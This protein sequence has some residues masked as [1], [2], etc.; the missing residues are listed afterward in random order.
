MYFTAGV[1]GNNVFAQDENREK[2][3]AVA[4]FGSPGIPAIG[5]PEIG[6]VKNAPFSGD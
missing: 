2:K 6:A 4:T 1:Y 5:R 3:V